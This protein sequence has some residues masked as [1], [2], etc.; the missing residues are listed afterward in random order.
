MMQIYF[1]SIILNLITGFVLFYT[2]EKN[3]KIKNLTLFENQ[4]LI[5]I[6]GCLSFIIGIV[7]LFCVAKDGI[8]VFGD[9]IPA[10]CGIVG[11]AALLI[12]Y[13][14]DN[15]NV[16]LKLPDFLNKLLFDYSFIIGIVCMC[17]A[18][19]HF[20]FPGALFL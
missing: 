14:S 7:K 10:L 11:G 3:T 20:F 17:S 19:L 8:A 2:S 18:I 15:S 6:L 4:V 13:Y 1:L 5:L 12:H 9:F 16:E